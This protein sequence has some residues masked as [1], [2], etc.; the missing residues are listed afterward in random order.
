MRRLQRSAR[1][2]R[3][4][5]TIIEVMVS[6]GVMTVG[7]LAILAL[8]QHTIRSNLHARQLSTAMQIAQRWVGRFKQDA[9]TWTRIAPISGNPSDDIVLAET[10]YLRQIT[11]NPNQYQAIPNVTANVSNAFD[12]L[13]NDVLNTSGN[14]VYCAAFRPAWVYFGRTMRVDVRVWWA[15]EGNQIISD[16]PGCAGT[17]STLD[18]GPSGTFFNNSAY[19]VVYLPS[20]IRVNPLPR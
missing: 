14:V 1:R 2:K 20:V 7:A 10:L 12:F 15:R 4:G 8:Q 5:F 9:H 17:Q 3:S 19:H 13:G 11:T 18:P 6:L 16:F